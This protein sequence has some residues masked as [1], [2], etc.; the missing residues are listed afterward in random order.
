MLRLIAFIVIVWIALLPPLFTNGACT[1]EFE[2]AS[3]LI[4]SNKSLLVS[5]SAASRFLTEKAVP[6]TL[7]TTAACRK[8]KPRFLD[9]CGSGPL[10]LIEAPV[11][12]KICSIYRDDAT[13]IQLQYDDRDR[14]S[15][16]AIDMKPYKSLPLPWGGFLHWAR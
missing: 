8:V 10:I 5:P 16:I 15:Q 11:A 9:R 7:L 1:A 2:Q 3:A 6:F 4:E 12:S 13:R 14:L